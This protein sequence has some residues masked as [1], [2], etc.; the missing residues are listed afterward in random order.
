MFTD[1]TV[2]IEITN[3][4]NTKDGAWA[5]SL[6]LAKQACLVDLCGASDRSVW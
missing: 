6:Q 3:D 4:W 5:R 1:W 2:E